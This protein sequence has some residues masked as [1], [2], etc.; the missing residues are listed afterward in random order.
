[1]YNKV[2]KN[3]LELFTDAG[4]AEILKHKGLFSRDKL[5]FLGENPLWCRRRSEDPTWRPTLSQ[6]PP[7]DLSCPQRSPHSLPAVVWC[8]SRSRVRCEGDSGVS[9]GTD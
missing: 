9:D 5:Q 8:P 7:V 3:V 2:E 1:M 4:N 6:R